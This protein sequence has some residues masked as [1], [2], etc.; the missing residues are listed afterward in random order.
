MKSALVPVVLVAAFATTLAAGT[1][2]VEAPSPIPSL[3]RTRM[4]AEYGRS[5]AFLPSW[6]PAGFRFHSWAIDGG[7]FGFLLDRLRIRLRNGASDLLWE[8]A[9]GHS[10]ETA[11]R[12]T[13]ERSRPFRRINERKV[14][15][16]GDNT[17]YTCISAKG[18]FGTALISVS[19]REVTGSTAVDISQLRKMVAGATWLPSGSNVRA[20]VLVPRAEATAL[21]AAF[22]GSVP[23]PTTV[24]KGFIFTRS[25]VQGRSAYFPRT[26][27]VRFGRDGRRLHWT[28]A[29]SGYGLDTSCPRSSPR[30]VQPAWVIKGRRVYLIQGAKGQSAWICVM[31]PKRI[32]VE[33]WNDYSISAQTLMRMVASAHP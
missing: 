18:R 10:A 33:V 20:S 32:T 25:F 2:A 15:D 30:R 28:V 4:T 29:P 13:C 26:A 21:R 31:E 17:A 9:S 3:E 14:Y 19:V 7:S 1:A 27:H 16:V 12:A 8:V 24:P 5:W 23:L 22:G 6:A 11:D